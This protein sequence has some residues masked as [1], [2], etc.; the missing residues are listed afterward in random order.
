MGDSWAVD[1]KEHSV[2]LS[3]STDISGVSYDNKGLRRKFSLGDLVT[4][5]PNFRYSIAISEIDFGCYI[6][7]VTEAYANYEYM[8]TWTKKPSTMANVGM[9]NGDD[10]VKLENMKYVDK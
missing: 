2:A 3:G 8:I 5:S 9:F 7:I 6:G 1:P 10:L 4:L